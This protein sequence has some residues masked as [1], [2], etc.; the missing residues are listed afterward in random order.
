ML[1]PGANVSAVAIALPHRIQ[2]GE[3]G[4]KKFHGETPIIVIAEQGTAPSGKKPICQVP[5]GIGAGGEGQKI[6]L[7]EESSPPQL[8]TPKYYKVPHIVIGLDKS[9]SMINHITPSDKTSKLEHFKKVIQSLRNIGFPPESKITLLVFD[10]NAKVAYDPQGRPYEYRTDL[11]T[12]IDTIGA[13]QTNSGTNIQSLVKLACDKVR[14]IQ[15]YK[16]SDPPRS[17]FMGFT[18]GQN[19]PVAA[20]PFIDSE[21]L[22][23]LNVTSIWG[24]IGA[25]YDQAMLYQ[26]ASC[27][28]PSFLVHTP[29][30][31][32]ILGKSLPVTL[33]GLCESDFYLRLTGEEL[34]DFYRITPSIGDG[35]YHPSGTRFLSNPHHQI[36]G[37]Y[38]KHSVN[39]AFANDPRKVR[40]MLRLGQYAT[41]DFD[42]RE[43]PVIN[44]DDA[45]AYG[46]FENA[47]LAD[48]ALN[49]F[50]S[51]FRKADSL[52]SGVVNDPQIR[53]NFL[54]DLS[55]IGT[56]MS[57]P[58]SPQSGSRVNPYSRVERLDPG[59][60]DPSPIS[61]SFSSSP[62]L[63][64]GI[65][66][67][68]DV[69]P[70]E[71]IPPVEGPKD[72]N[73]GAYGKPPVRFTLK[74][75]VSGKEMDFEPQEGESRTFG[76]AESKDSHVQI[77][78]SLSVSRYHFEIYRQGE[79]LLIRDSNS[80]NGT[81][82]NDEL[83][84]PD[85]GV[86]LK[87]NDLV[88]AGGTVFR[89]RIR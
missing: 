25:D 32:D 37:G 65:V 13:L 22:R 2:G 20:S 85:D 43:I 4:N 74:E 49:I 14:G 41:G 30:Q 5:V 67:P 88:R 61:Q 84:L 7:V 82:L 16:E 21:R 76:R 87:D 18:D 52:Q 40:L 62:G 73:A 36:W 56:S 35:T 83:L 81:F 6:S 50:L 78:G 24:G 1:V 57:L 26:L 55:E 75:E 10:R 47:Q 23:D 12:L 45:P 70:G 89:V 63:H 79:F 33:Q 46:E 28:G 19:N 71:S 3:V 38:Q 72:I 54:E 60:G 39:L 11:N 69:P 86:E 42:E 8:A 51:Y 27:S 15:E 66:A 53:L 31:G 34:K 29:S 59:S 64:S 9:R 80:S 77:P 48:R 44:F 17:L 68:L 58:D